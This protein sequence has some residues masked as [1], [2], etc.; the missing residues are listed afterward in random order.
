MLQRGI[1]ESASA[2]AG[3]NEYVSFFNSVG[4]KL[5]K[6]YRLPVS[7]DMKYYWEM[8]T[9]FPYKTTDGSGN[10]K[11]PYWTS[12]DFNGDNKNDYAYILINRNSG[13]KQLI[14][15]LSKDDMYIAIK[16]SEPTDDEMGVA[17][18]HAGVLTTASGKGYWPPTPEDPPE[19]NVKRHAIAYFAFESAA[20]VFVWNDET[21]SFKQHWL[22]D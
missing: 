7:G 17:T 21:K 13:K 15:F 3:D 18:Q 8:K 5:V 14:V 1:A 22:S 11:A 12:G 16:L 2:G 20:S 6:E 9:G 4:G 19:I 10:Y